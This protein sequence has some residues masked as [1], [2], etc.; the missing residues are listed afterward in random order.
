MRKGKRK[1][2]MLSRSRRVDERDFQYDFQG[3]NQ[4]QDSELPLSVTFSWTYLI[5]VTLLDTATTNGCINNG[6]I[7][8]T[9]SPARNSNSLSA[10]P[11][12]P[13]TLGPNNQHCVWS[14]GA[15]ACICSCVLSQIKCTGRQSARTLVLHQCVWLCVVRSCVSAPNY[16]GHVSWPGW[17][18]REGDLCRQSEK[19]ESCRLPSYLSKRVSLLDME[20]PTELISSQ[21]SYNWKKKKRKIEPFL[22][23]KIIQEINVMYVMCAKS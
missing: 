9:D 13:K 11:C 18:Q 15:A 8:F 3:P 17:R 10:L 22:S 12:I 2:S 20:K 6:L 16:L 5:N 1:R 14:V 19:M 21:G 23:N 4:G 7:T